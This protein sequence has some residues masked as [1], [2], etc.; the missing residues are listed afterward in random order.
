MS[1][2]PGAVVFESKVDNLIYGPE[3]LITRSVTPDAGI[4][5]K[6]GTLL[7]RVTATGAVKPSDPAAEDGSEVPWAIAADDV[8]GTGTNRTVV[9]LKGHFNSRAVAFGDHEIADVEEGL[10]E[11]GIFLS[12]SADPSD[13]A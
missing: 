5:F 8:N 3:P 4:D 2:V 1:L 12:E 7:G 11:K 6:R 9:Y 13:P 10:R